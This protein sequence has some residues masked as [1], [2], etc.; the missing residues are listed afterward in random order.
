MITAAHGP[1]GIASYSLV[2]VGVFHTIVHALAVEVISEE[3]FLGFV[4]ENTS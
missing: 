4:V 1:F 3:V 2:E